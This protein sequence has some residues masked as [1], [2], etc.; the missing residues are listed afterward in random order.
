MGANILNTM[1]EGIKDYL[2]ELE[3]GWP[4][5]HPVQLCQPIPGHSSL[6]DSHLQSRNQRSF[7]PRNCQ[8]RPGQSTGSGGYLPVPPPITVESSGGIDALVVATGKWL[9]GCRMLVPMPMLLGMDSTEVCRHGPLRGIIS[10]Q[11][12]SLSDCNGRWLMASIQG[13]SSFW[14]SGPSR[15]LCQPYR[16]NWPSVKILCSPRA[17]L[18]RQVA[19]AG[20]M[21]LQAKSLAIFWEQWGRSRYHRPAALRKEKYTNWK[22]PSNFDHYG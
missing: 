5:G 20:H 10:G 18:S 6:S 9:A 17:P 1:L 15:P 4:H 21:K 8:N 19:Q 13:S 11:M 22:Q 7:E 16:G 3:S 12:T 2:E 14:Y